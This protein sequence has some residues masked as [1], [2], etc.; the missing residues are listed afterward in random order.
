MIGI[1]QLQNNIDA[2]ESGEDEDGDGDGDDGKAL[3]RR[4]HPRIKWII[5]MVTISKSATNSGVS[6][7]LCPGR[8][9][10]LP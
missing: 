4:I 6:L 1:Y 8:S 10:R 7:M 2:Q 9:L 5:F 3:F